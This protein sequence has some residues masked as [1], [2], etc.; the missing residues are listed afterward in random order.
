MAAAHVHV[1]AGEP[2]LHD[3]LVLRWSGPK[4]GVEFPP[5]LVHGH[6]MARVGDVRVE[7][8]VVEGIGAGW[9]QRIQPA[10]V[11]RDAQRADR[12][13]D[14]DELHRNVLG[15]VRVIAE[16]Q[17][18]PPAW[19]CFG[20]R[21]VTVAV[22]LLD[23]TPRLLRVHPR[24]IDQPARRDHAGE[25]THGVGTAAE[26]EQRD[27]VPRFIPGSQPVVGGHDVAVKA[28]AQGS[29][30]QPGCKTA[31]GSHAGPV[32]APLLVPAVVLVGE[33]VI[34]PLHVGDRLLV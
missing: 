15:I 20:A 19:I 14:S 31:L 32:V 18:V 17:A 24:G 27:A 1:A 12:V 2:F 8:D 4:R 21:L 13:P 25:A 7:L 5:A 16:G 30:R 34:Q 22:H 3:I 29:A 9:I 28:N 6:G 33:C 23:L 26:A 10:Q 11:V